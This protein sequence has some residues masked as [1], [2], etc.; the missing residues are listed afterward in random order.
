MK[1]G[2]GFTLIELLVVIAIIGILAAILLPALARAREAARRASCANNLK[3]HGLIMKMYSNE[4]QGQ[5]FPAR[6]G[7]GNMSLAYMQIYPEYLTEMSLIRCP[8][9]S[10]NLNIV[11]NITK[12]C[13]DPKKRCF[14]NNGRTYWNDVSYR[15]IG[16]VT[17]GPQDDDGRLV[18]LSPGVLDHRES[19]S[20]LNTGDSNARKDY[21]A[22]MNYEP[23]LA[24]TPT[25]LP[26]L[27][28]HATWH[29]FWNSYGPG[30]DATRLGN[31]G[32]GDGTGES[33]TYYFLRE[34]VERFAITDI[35][36]PASSAM[37]QSTIPVMLDR[38]NLRYNE[39]G[40]QKLAQFNHLPGGCNVLFMDGH[41]KF[42][43]YQ[44]GD[45]GWPINSHNAWLHRW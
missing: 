33:S 12:V 15:Y 10:G 43:K 11:E 6:A 25:G 28:P 9:D 14:R 38:L 13:S 39:D 17:T 18:W 23:T 35:Y 8:S 32:A 20:S 40:S 5:K 37:A 34:G 1:K 3:Q 19:G 44:E 24:E 41:V 22:A 27:P 36:N 29:G 45:E 30:N 7:G 31:K 21:A 16:Y 4:S 26:F 42:L 2:E